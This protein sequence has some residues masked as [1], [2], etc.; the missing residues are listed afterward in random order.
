MCSPRFEYDYGSQPPNKNGKKIQ[1]KYLPKHDER[2]AKE[3]ETDC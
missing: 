3:S 2:N 1:A